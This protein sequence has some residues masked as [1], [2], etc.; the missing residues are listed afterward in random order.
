MFAIDAHLDLA[1]NA[2][3]LNRDLTRTSSEVRL[4]EKELN[5]TDWPDRGLGTVTLPDL[6]AGS[7]GLV[8][9]TIISRVAVRGNPVSM[10]S[11]IGWWSP[12][13]AY[14]FGQSQLSWY[15]VMEEQ[16][17]MVQIN[18][19]SALEKHLALW[20]DSSIPNDKKPI[21]Y[22]LSLEGADSV[23]NMDYLHRYYEDGL[24]AI[25][26]AHYGPG[27]YAPGTR[28]DQS[29]LTE[30]GKTLLKEMDALQM[31]LDLTH[32]TDAG[33]FE[34]IDIYQ[35]P[36]IASHQNCRAII[37]GERQFSDEQIQEII[38]RD[39]VLGGALDVWMLYPDYQY[40]Q[41]PNELGV[42]MEALVPHFDHICQM[43]GNSRHIAFGTDL[44][45]L[46]GREQSPADLNT[47]ADIQ[48]F[49]ELLSARG[50]TQEDL[51]NIFHNNWLRVFRKVLK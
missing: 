2:I 30:A 43:A 51:E 32:L 18:S 26:P 1:T 42:K 15:R 8:I 45:G 17:E 11:L 27:R 5:L 47:I 13:Q 9:A 16:G 7:I 46:F 35:G 3:S 33:F 48:Q 39:G 41:D 44:D 36:V 22:I 29:G 38:N 12:A 49:K 21:G 28:S 37:P 19:A 10:R 14:A 4:L 20:N 24:R 25:G 40:G 6:R 34:A 23:I 31:I 50:Y